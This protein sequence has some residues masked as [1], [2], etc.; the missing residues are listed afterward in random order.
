MTALMS[1]WLEVLSVGF[2]AKGFEVATYI[3]RF[4]VLVSG[5]FPHCCNTSAVP[6]HPVYVFS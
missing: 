4:G 2:V 6:L 1:T 5:G 3:F